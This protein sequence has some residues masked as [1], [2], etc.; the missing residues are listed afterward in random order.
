ML[1]SESTLLHGT[2][3]IE[4]QTRKTSI[5]PTGVAKTQ[6]RRPGLT[7][8]R[9]LSISGLYRMQVNTTEA[10]SKHALAN[11]ASCR[12]SALAPYI[13][14]Q[15]LHERLHEGGD[16]PKKHTDDV[17]LEKIASS[18]PTHLAT[19]YLDLTSLSTNILFFDA[20]KFPCNPADYAQMNRL[21]PL[22]STVAYTDPLS[23]T[24]LSF[25]TLRDSQRNAWNT[26]FGLFLGRG[27]LD[28]FETIQSV[29]LWDV[30][31][32]DRNLP[33]AHNTNKASDHAALPLQLDTTSSP[34]FVP[35]PVP[36]RPSPLSMSSML[37]RSS[38]A[39]RP[40]LVDSANVRLSLIEEESDNGLLSPA[41]E[42]VETRHKAADEHSGLDEILCQLET[43]ALEVKGLPIP[44][45]HLAGWRDHIEDS[46]VASD[47]EKK[48]ND[49]SRNLRNAVDRNYQNMSD[50]D[51]PV[52][53]LQTSL[54]I[55]SH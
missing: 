29:P 9:K 40:L 21:T 52:S 35:S 19:V 15:I 18:T 27:K 41:N 33:N 50:L 37:Q 30:R 7:R 34:L 3:A 39:R 17:G 38:S 47:S 16:S 25:A 5:S 10:T 42:C 4:V 14:S 36:L 8:R 2:S 46:A 20:L 51:S 48:T 44:E 24:H 55:S 6:S 23:S 45:P 32:A 11:P 26:P 43:L 1:L 49:M 54:K 53:C 22:S 28:V 12:Q 31:H 13:N